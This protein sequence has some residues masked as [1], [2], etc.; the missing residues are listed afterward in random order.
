MYT[1]VLFLQITVMQQEPDQCPGAAMLASVIAA[2]HSAFTCINANLLIQSNLLPQHYNHNPTYN[3][4][5]QQISYFK[6]YAENQHIV[7]H[8]F[9]TH[10]KDDKLEVN[11]KYPHYFLFMDDVGCDNFTLFSLSPCDSRSS[12]ITFGD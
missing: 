3:P 8:F 2:G 9:S 6:K 11:L 12:R 1:N 7:L 5:V 10:D 4:L